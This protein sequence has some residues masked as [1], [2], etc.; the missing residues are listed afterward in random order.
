MANPTI[1]VTRIPTG[2]VTPGTQVIYT[3]TAAD[4]DARTVVNTFVVTD[5]ASHSTQV[6]DSITVSDPVTVTASTS[7]PAGQATAPVKDSVNPA[8]WRQTL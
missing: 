1:S 7:D 4:A 8:I 2:V 5:S 3:V 6:N